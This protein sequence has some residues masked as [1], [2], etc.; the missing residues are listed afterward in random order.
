L[1]ITWVG[2]RLFIGSNGTARRE[3]SVTSQMRGTLEG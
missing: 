1:V 2:S 3:I